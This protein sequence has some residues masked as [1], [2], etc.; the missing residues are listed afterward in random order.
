M[1][2]AVKVGIFVTLCLAVLGYLVFRIEDWSLFGPEGQR[3]EAI[4]D[5]V[6]GLDER[7]PVRVAGVRVASCSG[8]YLIIF[9]VKLKGEVSNRIP[10]H[11]AK[12]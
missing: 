9:I 7:A 12:R 4:F 11:V 3:V 2:Q 5:S 8:C 10:F 6:A 1:P